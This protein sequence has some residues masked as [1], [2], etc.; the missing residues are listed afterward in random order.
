MESFDYKAPAELFA[1][2]RGAT[3]STALKYR[4][5]DT[6]AEAIQFAI[7]QLSPDILRGS[8]IEVLD[9]RLEARQIREL[10]QSIDFPLQRGPEN[11]TAE[12]NGETK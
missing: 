11:Q 4:R 7:E 6:S 12:L 1:Y 10:Y 2:L 5:F 9:L 8:V 3:R